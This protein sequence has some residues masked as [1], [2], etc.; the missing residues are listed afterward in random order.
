MPARRTTPKGYENARKLRKV[1]TPAEKKLWAY[2]SNRKLKGIKFR[3]QHALGNYVPDFCAIKERLIIELDGSQHLEQVEY[4]N[5]RTKYFESLGYRVIR[6]WNNQI[7][8]D[9]NSVIL[10]ITYALEE[11]QK[12]KTA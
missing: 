11:N 7:M 5:E 12:G 4:D 2:I 8:N 10:V 6:F 1:L 9:M 3:K